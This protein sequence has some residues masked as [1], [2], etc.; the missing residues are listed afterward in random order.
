MVAN[1]TPFCHRLPACR[2][3]PQ[4][5]AEPASLLL[6]LGLG[7]VGLGGVARRPASAAGDGMIPIGHHGRSGVRVV[8]IVCIYGPKKC[9]PDAIWSSFFKPTP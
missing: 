7:V 9:D 3:H 1:T 5:V 8:R 6:G 2:D 4:A